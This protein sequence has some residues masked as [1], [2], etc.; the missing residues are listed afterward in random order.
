MRRG[1]SN[2]NRL[3]ARAFGAAWLLLAAGLS[4]KTV[5]TGG[6]RA[7]KLDSRPRSPGREQQRLRL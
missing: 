1:G 6:L 3:S 4:P 2:C 5:E 7:L